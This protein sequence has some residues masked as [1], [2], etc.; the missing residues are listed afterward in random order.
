M[1]DIKEWLETVQYKIT[2]GSSWYSNIPNLY[3]LTYW[4]E[5]QDG[6]STNIVFELGTTNVYEVDV[7]D[8]KK[9]RAFRMKD[10]RLDGDGEAWDNVEYEDIQNSE[11]FLTMFKQVIQDHSKQA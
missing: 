5:E 10:D 11:V 7:C 1:I 3:S 4:N 6:F 9:N 2:E 8:Y